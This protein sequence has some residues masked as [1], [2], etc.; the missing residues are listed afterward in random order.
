[1]LNLNKIKLTDREKYC[2]G[3]FEKNPQKGLKKNLKN[4]TETRK[5]SK[6]KFGVPFA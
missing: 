6:N 1:L 5:Q 3:K 2:E 4:R